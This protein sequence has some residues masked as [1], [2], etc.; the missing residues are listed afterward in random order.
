MDRAECREVIAIR[1]S[2]SRSNPAG[3]LVL[4]TLCLGVLI[5]QIDTSVV[6]LAVEP[7]GAAF[8]AATTELQWMLDAYNLVYAVLLLTGGLLADLYGRRRVFI[9]GAA[10]LAGAS[11][12]SAA[13]PDMA[14]LIAARAAAGVGAALL[15]PASLAIVRV[16]WQDEVER[17]RALGVWA[18]CNG[19]AFVIGP[20]LGG[21]LITH[22]GWQSVFL[23][24]VP[25]GL[26]ALV[27]AAAI[28]PESA[29]PKS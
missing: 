22:F 20:S 26:A 11:L 28:V 15:L 3:R 23:L 27:L 13:A 9:V 29:A 21:L 24:V 14:V 8:H 2:K 25:A 19:L 7:I 6:N 4:A 16:V 18:S 17:G 1:G 12:V 5:A 10:V